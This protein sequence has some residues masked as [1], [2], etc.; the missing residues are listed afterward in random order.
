M[1]H[2]GNFRFAYKQLIKKS[3]AEL[4]E[5]MKDYIAL[6]EAKRNAFKDRP[7]KSV[8]IKEIDRDKTWYTGY[9]APRVIKREADH[10]S[11]LLEN[12]ASAFNLPDSEFE[13]LVPLGEMYKEMDADREQKA[14]QAIKNTDIYL[15]WDYMDV[16]VA[17]SMRARWEF[18]E[19][20]DFITSLFDRPQLKPLKLRWFDPTQSLCADRIDKGL[21]EG[22]MIKR[23]YCTVYMAQETD[24]M[25][26]DSELAATLAQGKPVIAYVPFIDKDKHALKIKTY[27]LDYFKIRSLILQAEGMFE[28]EKCKPELQAYDPNFE[29]TINEF[30]EELA[31]YR[32]K[33]PFSLWQEKED[34][35]KDQIK[36]VFERMYRIL[37]IAEFHNF[38]KRAR[39]L[40]EIHPLALQVDLKTGVTNGVLVVRN[41]EDCAGLLHR[42]LIN[43]LTFTIK[44]IV[45]GASGITVLEEDISRCPFR[46]VT[47]YEKLTNSFWNFY[48]VTP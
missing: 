42:I 14:R 38:E 6:P 22:L 18:E 30:H 39:T 28:D 29:E 45:K 13:D 3:E 2:F 10:V 20:A 31:E 37:T 23:A 26:K 41:V 40:R 12:G 32:K 15:T 46:A 7:A 47:D 48:L 27:P 19:T 9:I 35:F 5:I 33:Q 4:D 34:K 11:K 25:G 43:S 17:T 36:E 24:T 44:H 16:Y 8:S 1:L 21:I